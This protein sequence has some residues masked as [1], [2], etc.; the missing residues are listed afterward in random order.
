M[1]LQLCCD[2]L[3]SLGSTDGRQY[4]IDILFCAGLVVNT[5]IPTEP[6]V[7]VQWVFVFA[8]NRGEPA[9][10][11]PLVPAAAF[12]SV[13]YLPARP[14]PERIVASAFARSFATDFYTRY[15]SS[16]SLT[17]AQI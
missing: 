7:L 12:S 13:T 6:A 14:Y 9:A 8:A 5:K 11:G 3:F 17:I 10:V 16:C 2:P 15:R 4:E 1:G